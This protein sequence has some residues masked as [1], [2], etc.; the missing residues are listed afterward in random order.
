MDA[1]NKVMSLRITSQKLVFEVKII[2]IKV[3]KKT[4]KPPNELI[5]FVMLSYRTVSDNTAW[6]NVTVC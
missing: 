4:K 2:Q 3:K 6:T 1:E 5:S